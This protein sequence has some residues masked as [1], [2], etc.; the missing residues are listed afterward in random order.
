MSAKLKSRTARLAAVG[1]VLAGIGLAGPAAAAAATPTTAGHGVLP[2][3][4]PGT[5]MKPSPNLLASCANGDDGTACNQTALTAIAH[6]RQTLERLGGLRFSLAAYEKLTPAEQLFVTA[7][8]ERTGRGLPPATVLSR[9]LDRVAQAGAQ[10]NRDPDLGAV[11]RYLPGGGRRAWAGANWA[12][13]WINPLGSDY[14]WMY[15]DGPGSTNLTCSAA[16]TA[17]CWGHRNIILA[18]AGSTACGGAPAG[19]AM[20]AGHTTTAARYGESDTEILAGVCGHLPSDTVFTWAQARKL[21]H[22][23]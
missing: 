21:L 16:S 11:P 2:P 23:G 17:G 13:G 14:G 5:S 18:S 22:I 9:S 7:D 10:A 4:D 20:G 1:A 19:L 12:G 8:L 3:R 15:D 6:A